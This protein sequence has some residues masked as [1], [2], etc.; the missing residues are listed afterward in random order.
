MIEFSRAKVFHSRI[1]TVSHKFSYPV[2]FF[3]IDTDQFRKTSGLVVRR[4][5]WAVFS[6]KDCDY[7]YWGEA[8]LRE[9]VERALKS[10]GIDESP[11]KIMLITSMRFFGYVFNPVSFFICYS[12]NNKV[13]A[14]IVEIN[15]T[16]SEKHIYVLSEFE[17]KDSCLLARTQKEFH[18]SPF[19]DRKGDYEF[20]FRDIEDE[21]NISIDILKDSKKVFVSSL[22]GK[23]S[24]FSN[25]SL[26]RDVLWHP[27]DLSFTM[28]RI[29]WQARIIYFKKKL[30][31]F[32]K[33]K[34]ISEN[35]LRAAPDRLVDR[36]CF[37]LLKNH[38]KTFKNGQLTVLLPDGRELQFGNHPEQVRAR[39]EVSSYS[40]F[41]DCILKSDIGL[42]ES[43]TKGSW[44]SINLTNV[45]RFFT[46]NA[47]SSE[48]ARGFLFQI[49]LLPYRIKHIVRRNSK[50]GS[51]K[52]IYA[53]YDLGN[54]FFECFLD[55]SMAYSSGVFHSSVE[56]LEQAQ[57]N[58]F[59][60]ILEKTKITKSDHV[61]EV[62]SGWGGFAIYAAQTT[63][64]RVTGITISKEQYDYSRA[65]IKRLGLENQIEI[66]LKDYRDLEGSFDKI[67]SIEM[68]EAVG[69]EYFDDYFSSLERLLAPNG[70]VCIQVITIPD[71]RYERYRLRT[72]WI[73]QYIFPG[74]LLPSLTALTASMTR[75]SNLF[76]EDLQN[77]GPSY[78]LTLREWSKR[79]K[80][81]QSQVLS[82]GFDD[83]FC[84]LWEYYLAICEAGFEERY[85]NDLHLVLTR[86]RNRKLD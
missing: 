5:S 64:C 44:S 72:D 74:A 45:L 6:F 20:R 52:N 16:F 61:L 79:F 11:K 32:T 31:V 23:Y 78:A 82:L 62:G 34:P 28:L 47:E 4:N 19:Y 54:K 50:A 3:K 46:L 60:S 40:F 1:G 30:P 10:H 25:F 66:I 71:Q 80:E 7:L 27:I 14:I 58:K 83:K 86:A 63:G 51:K 13:L 59:Q 49:R 68:L 42:G 53:H 70:I 24:K 17:L 57:L 76:V 22:I 33:P 36:I 2:V 48:K 43:Y 15:N 55:P 85:I 37:F 38:L 84:R 35:T 8:S 26:F 73:Q 9:K 81:R 56:S 41:T 69:H 77:I 29:L 18:V 67:V 21:L 39:L 65:K 75:S 12:S